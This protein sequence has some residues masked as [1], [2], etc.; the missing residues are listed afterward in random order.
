VI[1]VSEPSEALEMWPHIIIALFT[2][3]KQENLANAMVSARQPW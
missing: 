1:S 2:N 3:P